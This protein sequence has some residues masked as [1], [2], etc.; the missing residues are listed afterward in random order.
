[1]DPERV[2]EL[3]TYPCPSAA[4]QSEAYRCSL[5]TAA[6]DVSDIQRSPPLHGATWKG[7]A[8]ARRNPVGAVLFGWLESDGGVDFSVYREIAGLYGRPVERTEFEA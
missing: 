4:K 3:G 2:F 7:R 1:M 6:H 8:K 5:L